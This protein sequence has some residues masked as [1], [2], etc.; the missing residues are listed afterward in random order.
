M[1]CFNFVLLFLLVLFFLFVELNRVETIVTLYGRTQSKLS[2]METL[3][4]WST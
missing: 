2:W 3:R 4:T 1:S